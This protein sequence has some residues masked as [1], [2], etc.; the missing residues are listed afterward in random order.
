MELSLPRRLI[1]ASH[2]LRSNGYLA[3]PDILHHRGGQRPI[4]HYLLAPERH[5][6]TKMDLAQVFAAMSGLVENAPDPEEN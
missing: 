3:S 1:P 5:T 4:G 6:F 2:L